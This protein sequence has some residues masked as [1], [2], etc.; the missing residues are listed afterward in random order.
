MKYSI[1]IYE[2]PADFV[3][4]D[5]ETAEGQAYWSGWQAYVKALDDAGVMVPGGGAL[6]PPVTGTTV[7]VRAEGR[8]VHDGPYADTKEALGGLI[9]IE[10]PDLDKALDWAARCP[11]AASGAVEVRPLLAPME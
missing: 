6:L 11:A 4:R 3:L 2:T 7:R 5:A 9:M 8:T 10:V 1:L